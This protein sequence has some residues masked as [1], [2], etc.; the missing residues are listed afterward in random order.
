MTFALRVDGVGK[1][2][3]GRWIL[4]ELSV[5]VAGGEAL[6]VVG[7]NGAGKSTL[8]AM[9]AGVLAVDRGRITVGG[10]GAGTVAA[11]RQVGYVPEAAN[12]P[13]HLT[14][15]EVIALV[16]AVK[17]ARLDPAVRAALAL[18]DL[19]RARIDQMSL[20]MRRRACLGAALVGA[21]ALLV[22]DEPTNGLDAAGIATIGDLLA[23]RLEAG[24]AVVVASHDLAFLER[25]GVRRLA[26]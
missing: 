19:G 22:L 21:P 5:D 8:L 10:A 1:R 11:Q 17:G 24:A 26:L 14:G 13:G 20:G 25:L 7:P 15:D 4:R 6:G 16:A 3:G 23:A 18:D 2:L 9:I 12:P